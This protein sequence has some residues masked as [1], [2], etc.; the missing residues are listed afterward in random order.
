MN[1]KEI[2][3]D[4]IAALHAAIPERRG[5]PDPVV[6]IRVR[7]DVRTFGPIMKRWVS[8]DSVKLGR[9][10]TYCHEQIE[11]FGDHY[12]EYDVDVVVVDERD[13]LD[14]QDGLINFR[15]ELASEFHLWDSHRE[16]GLDPTPTI[17][18]TLS[19][20]DTDPKLV[21]VAPFEIIGLAV[22]LVK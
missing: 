15:L 21:G 8:A 17:V 13:S 10:E 2:S 11:M 18:A 5:A 22:K 6:R 4:M 14:H 1:A 7:R 16:W 3:D 9:F 20:Y 12:A 19:N